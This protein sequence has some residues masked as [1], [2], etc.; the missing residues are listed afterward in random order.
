[1]LINF[2]EVSSVVNDRIEALMKKM[3]LMKVHMK[4]TSW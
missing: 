4:M 1:M 3:L 2:T